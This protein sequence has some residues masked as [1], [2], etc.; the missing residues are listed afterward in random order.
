[1]KKSVIYPHFELVTGYT[2]ENL[3]PKR[4]TT[5]SAGY[6]FIVAE[7][8]ILPAYLTE[9]QRLQELTEGSSPYTLEEVAANTKRLKIKPTLV[10]T[11]VKAYIPPREYLQLQVRSSLP[12]KHWIIL[13]NGVGIIDGDYVDNPD[14]EGHI[15]FQL[16]NL[17]PYDIIL[18]KGDKIGQGIFLPYDVVPEET[19]NAVRQGGFGS[20][21]T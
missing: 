20:T 10:P 16:I 7:D 14:N 2:D 18:K 15:Y 6:D 8:T 12:L 17:F 19:V 21:G 13:A 11:G 4:S 1:M 9:Y 5:D 3:I